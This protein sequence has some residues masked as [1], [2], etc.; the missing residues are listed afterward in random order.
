MK[1]ITLTL[2]FLFGSIICFSQQ[3]D[4][5][6][7]YY[8][9]SNVG[10]GTETPLQ[11]LHVEDGQ[12]G[13]GD[14][15]ADNWLRLAQ[16]TA[17]GYGYDFEHNN[18]SVLIN[19]QGSINEALILGDVSSNINMVLF[20]ISHKE[21]TEWIPKM[22]LTGM[23]NLGLGITKPAYKLDV[24]GTIRATEIKVESTGGADFVF[25][26]DYQLRSLEEVEQFV[27]E[28]NHLPDIPSAK[29]MEE[30]GVGLAQ[31]NK[32]LLQKVEELTLYAISQEFKLKKK[33]E[34][35]K[36]LRNEAKN[37]TER[38]DE[39]ERKLK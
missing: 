34:E 36:E 1:K 23:G 14:Q 21:G 37:I 20:G 11:K 33:D 35:I 17:D 38:L 18:A 4:S 15:S 10:V 9:G 3:I 19:E 26:E 39:I 16:L 29:Q 32:L 8:K 5:S 27:E 7:I 2:S 30:E 12:V 6:P 25:E 24:A 22:T 13:I 28:N 31:M